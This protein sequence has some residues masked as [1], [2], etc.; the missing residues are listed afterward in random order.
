[1]RHSFMD[2][3]NLFKAIDAP[4]QAV[5]VNHGKGKAIVAEL[6]R[7]AKEFEPQAYYKTLKEAQQYSVNVFPNTWK[8]LEDINAVHETQPGE[9][10]YFLDEDH[11][12]EEFG[13]STGKA[14]EMDC[15]V[16]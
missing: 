9:G 11:Y 16:I 12:S 10:I 4:T 14:G 13:V 15:V 2:A 8:K 5:V 3:G 6:C 7:L 1:M